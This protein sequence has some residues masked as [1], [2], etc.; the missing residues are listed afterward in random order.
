MPNGSG[1]TGGGDDP[2]GAPQ[3]LPG[4]PRRA[5]VPGGVAAGLFLLA[6]LLTFG[7]M[8]MWAVSRAAIDEGRWWTVIANT[9]AHGGL[10]HLATNSLIIF[11]VS[12][13][14]VA[15]LGPP[16]SAWW[17]YG[18]LFLASGLGGTAL[19]LLISD[20]MAALGASGIAFGLVGLISRLPP[21]TGP[22]AAEYYQRL[23]PLTLDLLLRN[24]FLLLVLT[25]PGLM[26]PGFMGIAWQAHVGGFLTGFLLGP[27]FLPR[28]R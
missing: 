25:L 20:D 14:I 19:F 18:L 26:I 15:R 8:Y 23:R 12:G 9:F 10:M 16:P 21:P 3:P 17:R 27:L 6:Y 4:V 24:L 22:V 2:H 1:A 11:F 5:F 7:D 13:P 28:Y